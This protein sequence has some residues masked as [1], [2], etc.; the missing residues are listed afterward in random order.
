VCKAQGRCR[1]RPREA[2]LPPDGAGWKDGSLPRRREAILGRRARPGDWPDD[3]CD[4]G[5]RP[6]DSVPVPARARGVLILDFRFWIA[7]PAVG[8]SHHERRIRF[9]AWPSHL[10]W[11]SA[12]LSPSL[13]PHIVG[14]PLPGR[15]AGPGG[16][17]AR[18]A[19]AP[20]PTRLATGLVRD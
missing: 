13:T 9:A 10:I 6:Q 14:G 20:A 16:R 18:R 12:T 15:E 7:E 3:P 4:P 8:E 1:A 19:S 5:G 2:G 17:R 11:P